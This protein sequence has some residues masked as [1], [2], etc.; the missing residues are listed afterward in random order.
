MARLKTSIF[1]LTGLITAAGT[2]R[3]HPTL[4]LARSL[5]EEERYIAAI[6]TAERIIEY[7][8]DS[9]YAEAA[10]ELIEVIRNKYL[11][12]EHNSDRG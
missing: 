5:V 6:Y 10:R 2:S 9:A 3:N 7:Y 1:L 11:E 8:P 12:G 4:K